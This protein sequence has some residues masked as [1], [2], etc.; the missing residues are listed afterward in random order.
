MKAALYL[1]AAV[2]CVVLLAFAWLVVVYPNRPAQ[3]GASRTVA[4]MLDPRSSLDSVAS[5]LATTG[6]VPQPRVFALYAR[7][8][9][10]SDRLRTG[11]V[12][13]TSQMTARQLLQ[14]FAIGYG[15]TPLLITI[16][17]GWNRFDIATRLAD[18]GIC[19]REEFLLA[20]Q[21]P[22]PAAA[23]DPRA[24]SSEGY[25]FPDTYWLRDQLP[26]AQ[27]V[28]RLSDNAR[29]RLG[30]LMQSEAPAFE[31]LKSELG[32]GLHEIMVLASIVEKEAHAPSE[33]AVIAG[34]FLNRLRSPD[35]RPKR[36]QAD[37]T[38]A[39]GCLLT[40]TL[41][42]C[43][44]FDG[45]RVTRIMTADAQNQYNTYRFEGLPP[46]PIANPGISAL[47]AVLHPAKH[48]YFYFVARGDGQHTF[49]STLQAHNIAV[50]KQPIEP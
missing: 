22:A 38:V 27:V 36:L 2:S 13:V 28:E 19:T 47:R 33:Q 26:A 9:G 35:F 45:K 7:V 34:V 30:Q 4:V 14:R 46:A 6:L 23:I 20:V 3:K 17:E 37:P 44:G 10:A 39:Y 21:S 32:F 16:P 29:K 11:R 18:W 41:P 24:D 50:Q 48:D 12:L 1:L 8:L 42:G 31:Q 40:S 49:S 5:D 43:V 15:S 25:L